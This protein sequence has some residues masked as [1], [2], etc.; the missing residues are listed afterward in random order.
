MQKASHL[1]W[2]L[3]LAALLRLVHLDA[4]PVGRHAWRQCDTASVARNYHQ[5]GYRFAFPQIDWEIPGYVEMEFPIYPFAVAAAYALVGETEAAARL[6]SLLGSLV[7]LWMIYL[8]VRRLLGAAAALWASLLLAVLPM[9][10]YFGRAIMPESWMLAASAAGVYLFLRWSEEGGRWAY[11]LSAVAVALAC[12]LKPTSLY[13]GLPLLWLAWRRFGRRTLAQGSIWLYALAVIAPLV[14]W[15]GWAYHLGQTYGAS[16]HVLTAAGADKWGRWSLL[17]S[18][19]FYRRVFLEVLGGRVLTWA[20][21]PLLLVG[22]VLPHR[23]TRERLFDVWLLAVVM[24]LLVANGGSYAHDY[25]SLPILLPAVALMGKACARGWERRRA[26]VGLAILGVLALGGYRYVRY[27]AAER[28]WGPGGEP[29]DPD[30]AVAALLAA[31]TGGEDLVVSC[32]GTDPVWLYLSRRRGWGRACEELGKRQLEELT[33]RGARFLVARSQPLRQ[34][35][36]RRL[37]DYLRVFGRVVRDDETGFLAE[38]GPPRSWEQTPWTTAYRETFEEATRAASWRFESG[39]WTADARGL[40]G[41]AGRRAARALAAPAFAGCDLCRVEAELTVLRP[42]DRRAERR[43]RRGRRASR[44]P[45]EP[46]VS[47][48]AW[49]VDEGTHVTAT[50]GV[51]DNRLWLRQR[52]DGELIHSRAVS[53]ALA[54]GRRYAVELRF[55]LYDFELLLDGEPKLKVS[56]RFARPPFG[57]VGVTARAAEIEVGRL[58]VREPSG[59]R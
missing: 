24:A 51:A 15:Y 18:P 42:V 9:S 32:K 52:Q 55:D 37:G 8:L 31:A 1:L 39:T 34:L 14:V 26:L 48:R 54:R 43:A 21:L 22:L 13:L 2:I 5:G 20:G 23:S 40:R 28:A 19:D 25:Y 12:L 7:T 30:V 45:P 11:V 53:T 47:L 29:R 16:F 36:G 50:L 17:A 49:R 10:V 35:P 41:T 4:P 3:A 38:L 46:E 6:L 56:S 57:T 58:E 44:Q 27:L 33:A 59:P